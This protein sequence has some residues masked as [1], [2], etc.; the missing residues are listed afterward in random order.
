M[1]DEQL[2]RPG[3]TYKITIVDQNGV[4]LTNKVYDSLAK[5]LEEQG[6]FDD[7]LDGQSVT[8]NFI[9]TYTADFKSSDH[10]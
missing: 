3:Y 8:Q 6:I 9:V 10:K 2:K 5:A 1:T 4:S 7:K